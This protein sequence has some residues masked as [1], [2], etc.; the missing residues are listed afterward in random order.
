MT[1]VHDH[2]TFRI[3]PKI[4][5]SASS[6]LFFGGA[7]DPPHLAH[8][9]LPPMARDSLG[10]DWLLYAPSART[11]L[12]E[13]GPIAPDPDRIEMLRLMIARMERA[14]V[15]DI[16]I[17]RGGESYTVETLRSLRE[18]LLEGPTLRLLIGADQAV[19]FH[20]WRD[21]EEVIRLAEPVVMLRRSDESAEALLSRMA[22]HWSGEELE[23]WRRRIVDLPRIDV[24]STQIRE[25][26]RE[27]GADAQALERMVPA[28]ALAHIRANGL[29]Q[30]GES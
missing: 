18:E 5:D 22:S 1:H 23:R 25:I 21:P 19:Q 26:I 7:F 29:Y 28:A 15:S 11:P 12:K 3:E 9:R 16:E 8:Q 13:H 10:A 24:S 27:R 30:G 4:P 17:V 20:R 6:V 14:S 2:Q